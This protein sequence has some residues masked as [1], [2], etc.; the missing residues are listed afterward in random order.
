M[1]DIHRDPRVFENTDC[2]QNSVFLGSHDSTIPVINAWG[3][4]KR[5]LGSQISRLHVF[6]LA[7]CV[8]VSR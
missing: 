3:I 2:K 1:N 5:M 6:F 7:F 4:V 8:V